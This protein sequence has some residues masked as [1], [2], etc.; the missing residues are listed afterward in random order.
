VDWFIVKSN[1]PLDVKIQAVGE[2]GE[3]LF[4]RGMAY[5]A[6]A[7]S[8]GFIPETQLVMFG[9]PR[10]SSRVSSLVRTG[11]WDVDNQDGIPGY[12]VRNWHV[13]QSAA[14]AAERKRRKDAN[15][16]AAKRALESQVHI[17]SRTTV[18]PLEEK[19]SNTPHPPAQRGASHDGTHP[20]CR[21]CGTTRRQE[22][23][24]AKK[25]KPVWCGRCDQRTRLIGYDGPTPVRCPDCHPLT[26]PG[27][28]EGL[29]DEPESA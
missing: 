7:N 27:P 10:V 25:W 8:D 5:C 18:V 23:Q 2:R 29:A 21:T 19:R 11:L 13:I 24:A 26:A 4:F 12:R 20:N 9:L 17:D 15:A 14:Y 3:V 1:Y 6:G 28:V 22:A 16:A